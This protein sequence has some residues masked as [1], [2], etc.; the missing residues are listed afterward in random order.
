MP[1]GDKNP[2]PGGG[3][4]RRPGLSG[5]VV[6]GRG[7]LRRG[8]GG[9]DNPLDEGPSQADLEKLNSATRTCPE[10]GKEVFGDSEVCY[11]CGHAFLEPA[12]RGAPT[13]AVVTAALV[14]AAVLAGFLLRLW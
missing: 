11:H 6:S 1:S 3:A 5:D 8:G 7:R 12:R 4:I 9:D 14:V 2:G 13:W 10:C